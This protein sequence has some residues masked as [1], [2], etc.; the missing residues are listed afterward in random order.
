MKEN[1]ILVPI[2][3]LFSLGLFIALKS[4]VVSFSSRDGFR[5]MLDNLSSLF[6]RVVGYLAGL[7]AIQRLVGF[8][9]EIPW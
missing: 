8:P 3:A 1:M 5:A 4:G 2:L 9:L 7:V 6:L